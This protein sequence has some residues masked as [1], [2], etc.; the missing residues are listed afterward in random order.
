MIR[1]LHLLARKALIW[2]RRRR[3]LQ[4]FEVLARISSRDELDEELRR[5]HLVL[6]EA[7]SRPKWLYFM[8][9]CRCCAIISLNLMTSHSPHWSVAIEAD[10]TVTVWPSIFSTTC[11]SHFWIRRNRVE[12]C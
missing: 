6:L 12:W 8:C 3:C 7:A 1:V 2:W 10:G 5:G 4:R 11:G 9:P